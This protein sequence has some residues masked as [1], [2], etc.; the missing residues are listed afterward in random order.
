MTCLGSCK[1]GSA[2]WPSGYPEVF[3]LLKRQVF[4]SFLGNANG[5][6]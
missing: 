2:V 3:V 1:E 6:R 4:L 5:E